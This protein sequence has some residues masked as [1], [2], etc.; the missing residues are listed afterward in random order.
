MDNYLCSWEERVSRRNRMRAM[1]MQRLKRWK[2]I[3]DFKMRMI[4]WSR[5]LTG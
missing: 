3:R 5:H 1:A 2:Q 4:I